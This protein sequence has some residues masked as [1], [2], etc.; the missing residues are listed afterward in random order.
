MY[1][2]EWAE[3]FEGFSEKDP[4][5]LKSFTLFY[6]EYISGRHFKYSTSSKKMPYFI[7]ETKR[8]QMPHLMGL[9]KWNNID[10]KQADKQYGKLISGEW[11]IAFLKNAD[12][13]S[14]KEHGWRMEFLG[15]LYSLLY[16]YQCKV[17]LINKAPNNVFNKRKIDMVFQKDGSKLIYF[18]ELREKEENVFVPTSLTNYRKNSRALQFKSEPLNINNVQVERNMDHSK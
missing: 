15:Y 8:N 12:N 11:D 14:F 6:D 5:D 7:I 2:V 4:M 10:V 17:K 3:N 9:H 18:L 1:T 13:G 16:Q